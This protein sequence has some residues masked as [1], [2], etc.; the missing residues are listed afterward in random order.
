MEQ[1]LITLSLIAIIIICF[2]LCLT[3]VLAA[4]G[5]SLGVRR[6]YVETLLKVFEFGRKRIKSYA[7]MER[8]RPEQG[9]GDLDTAEGLPG[10]DSVPDTPTTPTTK[11]PDFDQVIHRDISISATEGITI[12]SKRSDYNLSWRREF[13]ISDMMYFMKCGMEC[14]IQDDVT[15]RFTAEELQSWNLLTRTDNGYQFISMRLTILWGAGCVVRYGILLP[16]RMV[17]CIFGLLFLIMST[18]LIG[19]IPEGEMK[20][21]L[22]STFSL[23]SHRILCRAMSATVTFHNSPICKPLRGICVANHTSPLD[24]V[25]LSCDNCY[26]MVGQSHGGFLGIMQRALSRATS[27]IWFERSEIK[28]RLLVSET[29]KEHVENEDKLPILIFPEGTCINNTSVMMFKKGGFEVTP[30]VYPVAIKY[31]SRF[32]DAFWNSSKESMVRH[33]YN[34]MTSW[35][36][37]ADVWY[38]PPMRRNDGEDAVSFAGRVKAEI[39][40]AGGL[41]DLEWDGQLKRSKVK[42]T[43]KSKS[44]QD[45]SKI[46]K[47]E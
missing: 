43:W 36:L 13:N 21:K 3:I 46:I 41:V 44:Q 39:A 33:I 9:E 42:D 24:V 1:V 34:I 32:G 10:E 14:I 37:V 30:I 47:A 35:A 17:L 40:R 38:L 2:I 20:R 8:H 4:L 31:D 6:L 23:M 7:E 19:Y 29:M 27:H 25:I 28:D 26:A 11:T 22:N 16:F 15:Q 45:Y 12:P 18:F 5:K